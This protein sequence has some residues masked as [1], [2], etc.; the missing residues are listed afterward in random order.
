MNT[1]DTANHLE[2]I[3]FSNVNCPLRE[4][5]VD[6]YNQYS[7]VFDRVSISFRLK[8]KLLFPYDHALDLGYNYTVRFIAPILLC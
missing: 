4:P 1:L 5:K 6:K 7:I 8:V 3:L 2:G